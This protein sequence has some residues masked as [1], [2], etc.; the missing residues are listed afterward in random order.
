MNTLKS[1][2]WVV[3]RISH[4]SHGANI[5]KIRRYGLVENIIWEGA[6]GANEL[7]NKLV[8]ANICVIPSYIESYCVAMDESLA[9]GVPTIASYSG[10]MPELATDGESAIFYPA[11]DVLTCASIIERLLESEDLASRISK[12]ALKEKSL[13]NEVDIKSVQLAIYN[14]IM[15][16]NP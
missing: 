2:C 16:E 1:T 11:G 8:K 4:D 5:R 15:N 12:N 7:V 13:K 14:Q 9:L 6:L 10:A 3:I